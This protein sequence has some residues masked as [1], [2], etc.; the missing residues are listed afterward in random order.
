MSDFQM[1]SVRITQLWMWLGA[2][3]DPRVSVKAVLAVVVVRPVVLAQ[4]PVLAHPAQKAVLIRSQVVPNKAKEC[5]YPGTN[6]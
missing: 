5:T 1:L 2:T 6:S 4:P 3:L